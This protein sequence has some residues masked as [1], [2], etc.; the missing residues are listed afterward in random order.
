[1]FKILKSPPAFVT[2]TVLSLLL[3]GIAAPLSSNSFSTEQVR[4][5]WSDPELIVTVNSAT[6]VLLE[7]DAWEGSGNYQV[8]V[9]NKNTQLIEQSFSTS[10]LSATVNDLS[11][12]VSYTFSVEKNSF[13]IAEDVIM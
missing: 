13:V 12:G 10:S 8:T 5:N 3:L 1:M 4:Q 6:S 2:L 9:F 11:T 7:W